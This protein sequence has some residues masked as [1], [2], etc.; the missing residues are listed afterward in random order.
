MADDEATTRGA[1]ADLR[2]VW[3]RKDAGAP[4]RAAAL[5]GWTFLFTS[6]NALPGAGEVEALL[7]ALAALLHEADVE[8][9]SSA[10]EAIAVV[11]HTCGLD[12]L[13]AVLE[14]EEEDDEADDE[15]AAG[16]EAGSARGAAAPAGAANGAARS[17]GG[18]GGSDA[19]SVSGL[20][21]V[22][23]RMRELAT[24]R[25]DRTR[26]SR[27]DRASLRGAFREITAVIEA[28]VLGGRARGAL[29]CG[30]HGGSAALA[31][32]ERP[33][34]SLNPQPP[35]HPQPP[36]RRGARDQDQAAPR[37]HAADQHAV[38]QRVH[39]LPAALPGG[40]LPGAQ[41]E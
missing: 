8:L 19:G 38:G 5:R 22:V 37:R 33:S 25:G 2:S 35:G 26:R 12:E 32:L 28:R 31:G 23:D 34:P 21:E 16:S 18:A 4:L 7:P 17:G 27:R 41:A 39:G 10:G 6:L 29:A 30:T 24:N 15:E 40:R 11:Y 3:A 36:G 14:E 20:S 13:E 9:R 1:M